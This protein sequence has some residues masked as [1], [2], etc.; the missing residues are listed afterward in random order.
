MTTTSTSAFAE[1]LAQ[2]AATRR[3]AVLHVAEPLVPDGA[4]VVDFEGRPPGTVAEADALLGELRSRLRPQATV[5][6]VLL[7]LDR[8]TPPM[9]WRDYFVDT[10]LPPLLETRALLVVVSESGAVA[11]EAEVSVED[12]LRLL[13]AERRSAERLLGHLDAVA[14]ALT[15]DEHLRHARRAYQLDA[16]R[17]RHRLGLAAEAVGWTGDALALA[18]D[19]QLVVTRLRRYLA[20]PEP[21]HLGLEIPALDLEAEL[22]ALEPSP[23]WRHERAE[24]EALRGNHAEALALAEGAP[25][26]AEVY[27]LRARSALALGRVEDAI[28]AYRRTGHDPDD[29]AALSRLV[30]PEEAVEL[31]AHAVVLA[32]RH[33]LELGEALVRRG[34]RL[35]GLR[36]AANGAD[37][38]TL[39]DVLGVTRAEA[40]EAR[41]WATRPHWNRL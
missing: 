2:V 27:R 17:A 19:P 20:A 26:T 33:W 15:P 4:L 30:E 13:R 11:P 40:E 35:V 3:G 28:A 31:A 14:H 7:G 9:I 8:A 24:L 21:S 12:R 37:V 10:L 16:A 41:E 38:D 22:D 1:A 25:D 34:D 36:V 29:L 32:Q 39:V 5:V 23:W 6:L 18:D